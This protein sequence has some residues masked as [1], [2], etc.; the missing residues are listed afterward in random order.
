MD[1]VDAMAFFHSPEF[2]IQLSQ[3]PL[4]AAHF[5][6][7]PANLLIDND[8]SL[9]LTD[10]GDVRIV[11][12]GERFET[13]GGDYNYGPPGSR[14]SVTWS[15]AYDVWSMACVL[16]E[17]IEYIYQINGCDAVAKFRKNRRA[18]YRDSDNAFWI[19]RDGGRSFEIRPSVKKILGAF[20]IAEDPYLKEVTDLLERMFAVRE[21]ERPSMAQCSQRF[22]I[23]F[24]NVTMDPYLTQ[25]E[26]EIPISDLG[27]KNPLRNM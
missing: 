19:P 1:V 12:K 6:L 23:I 13:S 27:T 22:A 17:I 24:Q 15:Q 21:S 26:G 16:T 14:K 4:T 11:C 7:K 10:F 20:K 25:Y 2:F 3:S 5:D 8:G 9:V 18:D